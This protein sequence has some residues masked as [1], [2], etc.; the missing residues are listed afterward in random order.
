MKIYLELE[1][2]LGPKPKQQPQIQLQPCSITLSHSNSFTRKTL[3][4][5]MAE[6]KRRART[7]VKRRYKVRVIAQPLPT[8]P[9]SISPMNPIPP[10]APAPTVATSI[11]TTQ[12]PMVKSAATSIPVTVYN[13][14]HGKF[15]GIPY[16]TG[17]PQVEEN[18][19]TPSYSP[20]QQRQQ[21]EAILNAPTF[22][23]PLNITL[24]QPPQICLK[25]KQICQFPLCK[26]PQ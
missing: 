14:A 25:P 20:P 12:T 18:P 15:E 24:Y 13:V 1:G 6:K 7:P 3:V 22:Q 8:N 5:K 23:T 19:S 11:T 9:T 10:T 2:K 21:P 17:R 4:P 16:P 26:H